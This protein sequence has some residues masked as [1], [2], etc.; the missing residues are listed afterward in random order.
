MDHSSAHIMEYTS[1]PVESKIITAKSL[2]NGHMNSEDTSE[3]KKHN[4][5]QHQ[6]SEYY[7]ELGETIKNFDEVLLFGPTDAKIELFNLLR[8]DRHFEK[9]K[10]DTKQSDKMTDNQQQ[11]FVSEYFARF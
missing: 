10:I 9:I 11:A 7:K 4:I 8:A 3:N 6:L 2:R 5:E 1:V